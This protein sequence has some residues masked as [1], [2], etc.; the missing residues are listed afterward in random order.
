[1]IAIE[2]AD[3][4]HAVLESIRE[5]LEIYNEFVRA[6][7]ARWAEFQELLA[8]MNECG[9]INI[10]DDGIK[11]NFLS[12]VGLTAREAS[13]LESI[14]VY[15]IGDVVQYRILRNRLARLGLRLE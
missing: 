13:C 14:G 9:K 5:Q 8:E 2:M 11:A 15:T 12:V 10:T 6:H 7:E 1:M 4:V 3:G